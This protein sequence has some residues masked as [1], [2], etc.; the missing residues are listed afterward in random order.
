MS[1]G[2]GIVGCGLI[3]Q[4]RAKALA[5]ARLVGCADLVRER[6][7]ALARTVPGAEATDDWRA[8]VARADLEVVV[9]ATTNESLTEIA[10]GAVEAGKHVLVEKP[11]ARSVGELDSLIAAAA[12]QRR[13][14][15]VGFNHR[16]HPAMR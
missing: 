3:G 10:R 5:G 4:K 13:L 2:V 15:R 12:R 8:L 11:A 9:V 6:A 14:V 7:D 16:F 1:R